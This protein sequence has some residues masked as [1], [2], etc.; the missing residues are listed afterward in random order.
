MREARGYL[1]TLHLMSMGQGPGAISLNTGR[2]PSIFD[3]MFSM[4]TRKHSSKMCTACLCQPY[5]LI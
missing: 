2:I 1:P 3:R 5:A 4:I